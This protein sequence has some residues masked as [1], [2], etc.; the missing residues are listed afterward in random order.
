MIQSHLEAIEGHRYHFHPQGDDSAGD[1]SCE[2][3]FATLARIARTPVAPGDEILLAGGEHFAGP[4]VIAPGQGGSAVAPVVVRSWGEGR[5]IIEA[6]GETPGIILTNTEGVEL[7]DLEVR[8]PGPEHSASEGIRLFCD[9]PGGLRL[10]HLRIEHVE[11][12]G[13]ARG[14]VVVGARHPSG[15]GFDDLM[16]NHVDCHDC[17]DAGIVTWGHVL[18]GALTTSHRRITLSHC[19][20]WGNHGQPGKTDHHTGSGIVISGVEG[21]LVE[22]CEAYNNGRDNRSDQGGPVGI[23]CWHAR[24]VVIQ[25]CIAHHNRTASSKDGGGFDIDGGCEDCVL[26]AN[27]SYANDG[28]G[29]MLAQ[30]EGAAAYRRNTIRFN[31]SQNDGRR[32]GYGGIHLRSCGSN[33]GM[34]QCRVHHNTVYVAPAGA[35]PASAIHASGAGPIEVLIANNRLLVE[36]C[37]LVDC[38]L[39]TGLVWRDNA[40]WAGAGGAVRWG[41]QGYA[42]ISDWLAACDPRMSPVHPL[43]E[44]GVVAAGKGAPLADPES[45]GCLRAYCL[46][47]CTA[48]A[49]MRLAELGLEH[50]ARDFLGKELSADWDGVGAIG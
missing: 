35:E 1:G 17:G 44:P 2:R 25:R 4:L 15:S 31:I 42:S 27:Y 49:G 22:L 5:A 32:N 34:Q 10:R 41:E 3:P 13:F 26:Q 16:M 36:G 43:D 45:L 14:G 37:P 39:I 24:G 12:S 40:A 19:R 29:F 28:A 38:A 30:Y 9:L 46:D 33:G 21:A 47:G 6:D 7:R 11:V 50:G 48:I 8:G 20:A 23:W 18:P